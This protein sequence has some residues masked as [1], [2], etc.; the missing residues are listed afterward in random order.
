MTAA[1]SATGGRYVA[2]AAIKDAVSSREGDI[3]GKLGI[4]WRNGQ[5]HIHCPYP[6]HDDHDPSWRWDD[7]RHCAYCTCITKSDGIFDIVMKVKRLD[8][9]AAKI[10]VAEFIDRVDLI[11]VKGDGTGQK[12]D[13]ASLLNP[14]AE[15]SDPGLVFRYLAHRLG[16][17]DPAAVP[18]PTTTAVGWKQ[19]GYYDP[20]SVK[21]KKFKLVASPPCI[22]FQTVA[23]DGRTHAHRIYLSAAGGKAELGTLPNGKARDPKKSAQRLDGQP[24]TAGCCVVWG[25]VTAPHHEIVF[26]GIENAAAGAYS[27]A[28]EIATGEIVVVSA[29][30]AGG[31]EAFTPW[32]AAQTLTVAADRDEGKPGAGF[33]RGEKAARNFALRALL[34]EQQQLSIQLA[35]PGVPGGNTDFLDLLLVE[36]I[37]AVRAAMLA[38][39]PFVPTEEEIAE[40][41]RRRAIPNTIARI[42]AAYPLPRWLTPK[43]EYLPRESGEIW[44]HKFLGMKKDKDTGEEIEVWAPICSPFTMSAWLRLVDDDD[45]Y[46]VRV[47]VADHKGAPHVIDFQRGELSRLGASEIRSRLM[48]AGMRVANGGEVT[49]VEVLK[50][51]APTAELDAAAV[52]GWQASSF[53]SPEGEELRQ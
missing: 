25:D 27:F 28:D 19:L 30:N 32:P 31:I 16:L 51:A 36:G 24:S 17:D 8:F 44:V 9:E 50:E 21:E 11:K 38:P 42:S 37:A 47:L 39:E 35:L 23:A 48:D 34:Q 10:R 49:I 5:Q 18:M 41:E 33:K 4:D 45:A 7:K 26:E 53:I 20:P 15:N 46:G 12:T 43:L 3:L 6:D 29:I 14:P 2:T 13:A 40:F 1:A 52:T 22:V